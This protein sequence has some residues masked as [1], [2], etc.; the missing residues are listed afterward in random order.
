[1]KKKAFTLALSLLSTL[2]LI[3]CSSADQENGSSIEQEP[4][5]STLAST[6]PAADWT[7]T[8]KVAKLEKTVGDDDIG[9][10][11]LFTYN[12][13][14]NLFVEG[15][16]SAI[17]VDRINRVVKFI[18]SGS[19]TITAT[20]GEKT[21]TIAVTVK[22]SE[23]NVLKAK[24]LLDKLGG[25]YYAAGEDASNGSAKRANFIKAEKYVFDLETNKGEGVLKDGNVYTIRGRVDRSFYATG[26][27]LGTESEWQKTRSFPSF[28]PTS[29]EVSVVLNEEGKITSMEL[30]KTI[31]GKANSTAKAV[32]SELGLNYNFANYT[33]VLIQEIDYTNEGFT[34]YMVNDQ[35]QVSAYLEVSFQ[36][37][38]AKLES[39]LLTGDIPNP[40]EY[41][42]DALLKKVREI[43]SAKN[44]RIMGSD[45]TDSDHEMFFNYYSP[46]QYF[47]EFMDDSF[48]YYNK[49]GRVY[50]YTE[51]EAGFADLEATSFGDYTSYT[52]IVPSM[53]SIDAELFAAATMNGSDHSMFDY[54][55]SSDNGALGAY[56]LHTVGYDSTGHNFL[57]NMTDAAFYITDDALLVEMTFTFGNVNYQFDSFGSAELPTVMDDFD[58]SSYIGTFTGTDSVIGEDGKHTASFPVTLVLS[59]GHVGTYTF[60]SITYGISWATHV[61][62]SNKNLVYFDFTITSGKTANNESFIVN[63]SYSNILAIQGKYNM[64]QV[65]FAYKEGVS[66]KP[67]TVLSRKKSA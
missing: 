7:V 2:T 49:N 46:V 33:R 52:E 65:A 27:S 13:G 31:D 64:I 25:Y 48:G 35:S 12:C 59:E 6:I 18:A 4:S 10:D 66:Y 16:G 53:Y 67:H 47:E 51:T 1:M 21:A 60:N 9:F 17:K 14:D 50:R 8:A 20:A 19:A 34:V 5:S 36:F 22:E 3:S 55:P 23:E 57:D 62:D 40:D 37:S 41:E 56:L 32:L 45:V 42:Q 58:D 26:L 54:A 39:F 43:Q 30:P 28:S 29:S 63:E 15:K 61:D 11:E 38:Y 44:Y 24:Q